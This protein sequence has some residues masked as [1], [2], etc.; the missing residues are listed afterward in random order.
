MLGL[1]ES[2]LEGEN[3]KDESVQ[4]VKI[5][6]VRDTSQLGLLLCDVVAARLMQARLWYLLQRL[7]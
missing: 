3:S 7:L 6:A 2:H 4:E 1:H 5:K